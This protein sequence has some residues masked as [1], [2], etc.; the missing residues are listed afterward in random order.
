[1]FSVK[2]CAEVRE[3]VGRSSKFTAREVQL[4]AEILQ[5]VGRAKV[6]VVDEQWAVRGGKGRRVVSCTRKSVRRTLTAPPFQRKVVIRSV[7][8]LCVH[9]C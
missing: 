3:A 6:C 9:E 8:A 2:I 1:M 5:V 7:R 4:V